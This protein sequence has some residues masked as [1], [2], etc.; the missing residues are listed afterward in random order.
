MNNA[1]VDDVKKFETQKKV[2]CFWLLDS[3]KMLSIRKTSIII[4]FQ[5][6]EIPSGT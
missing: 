1:L 3:V 5:T 2:S 4:L 6:Q